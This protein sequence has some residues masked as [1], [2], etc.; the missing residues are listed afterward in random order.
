MTETITQHLV[1]DTTGPFGLAMLTGAISSSFFFFGNLSL[2]MNGVLPATITE[3]ERAKKGISDA[4]ALKL[5]EW[6]FY[7]A[8]VRLL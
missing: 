6:M 7:R 1:R 2:A 4:S 5:W 3:S 8:K